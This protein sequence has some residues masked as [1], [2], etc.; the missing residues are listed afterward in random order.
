MN[1]DWNNIAQ[2]LN[3]TN[4]VEMWTDLYIVQEKGV[5]ELA[6]LFHRSNAT[7]VRR[8][9]HAGIIR[10]GKGGANNIGPATVRTL[11]L[12]CPRMLFRTA[13]DEL[14]HLVHLPI[15]TILAVKRLLVE[16]AR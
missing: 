5:L 14:A 11:S 7:I 9:D 8:L 12:I 1:D 3:Y 10:R 16:R 15:T 13:V 4:E 6:K 2:E